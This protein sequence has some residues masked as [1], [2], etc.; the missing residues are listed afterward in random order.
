V[1]FR[2]V[3]FDAGGTLLNPLPSFHE[4]FARVL[5][6]HGHTLD[7]GEIGRGL[8][9]IPRRFVEAADADERWTT[10]PQGSRKFWVSVY[11]L[12]LEQAGL[13]TSDGLQDA[14]YSAFTDVHNYALLPD[15]PDTLE[16]LE[17]AGIALGIISNFEDWLDDL[18]GFLEVR[19]RFPV[20]V[21]SGV[22]GVEKPDPEIFRRALERLDLSAPEVVYVGDVPAIDIRPAL[23]LG[24]GAVLIDRH[25]RYPSHDGTRIRDLRE[26]VAVLELA[27]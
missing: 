25:D 16:R 10:S 5:A 12:F 20:R 26:L 27:A 9:A 1:R 23:E 18:L 22:E 7:P 19:D 14:L 24:M 15:V 3:V 13:P 2:A 4:L 21:I 6:E 17:A 8:E 11:D